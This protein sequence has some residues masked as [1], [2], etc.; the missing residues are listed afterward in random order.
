MR[1]KVL[2][3]MAVTLATSML[4]VSLTGCGNNVKATDQEVIME[5]EPIIVTD[6]EDSEEVTVGT[7]DEI[8]KTEEVIAD[9]GEADAEID[10][11]I[12]FYDEIGKYPD[13]LIS[14]IS[15][16]S[17]EEKA[18][19]AINDIP[20]YSGEGFKVGYVKGGVTFTLTEHGINT[21]WYRFE[22]PVS[23]T[24]YDYL[25]VLDDD[26]PKEEIPMLSVEEIKEAII[27]DICNCDEAPVFLD[28]PTSD[29][30]VYECRIYREDIPGALS[31]RII[32]AFHEEDTFLAGRY[33]TYYLECEE[34]GNFV[35]CRLYYK[36]LRS[37]YAENAGN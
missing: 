6:E 4:I 7:E 28:A 22:N 24:D 5:E 3:I 11:D 9:D 29:M 34:D 21:R 17:M 27:A 36:D 18:V 23:G 32:E 13:Y 37:I 1:K 8:T 35:V 10:G 15:Y 16:E 12:L 26:L 31:L 30:E 25:C 2:S 33:M 19:T 20:V 14:D